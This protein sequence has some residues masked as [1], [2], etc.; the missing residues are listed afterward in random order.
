MQG[1]GFPL[2][3]WS[4]AAGSLRACSHC[5]V[6]PLSKPQHA[7]HCC[8]PQQWAH[9]AAC[10][11]RC[12]RSYSRL[13]CYSCSRCASPVQLSS[14]A[15]DSPLA[16]SAL[17]NLC[18]ACLPARHQGPLCNRA[19]EQQPK[20]LSRR[21]KRKRVDAGVG[22]SCRAAGYGRRGCG[23]RTGAAR[24]AGP[25]AAASRLGPDHGRCAS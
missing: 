23:D 16:L 18:L 19:P 17:S 12:P 13:P 25:G 10:L 22:K 4:R 1:M 3:S 2:V 8:R 11:R 24:G 5:A 15:S 14:H 21:L 20:P 6:P 9:A 7:C